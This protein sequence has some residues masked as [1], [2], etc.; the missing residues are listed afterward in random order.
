MAKAKVS[1]LQETQ[2]SDQQTEVKQDPLTLGQH[3]AAVL[4]H[5]DTPEH[6]FNQ[7]VDG[8]NELKTGEVSNSAQFIQAVIDR[9]RELH[10]E[11]QEGGA[12]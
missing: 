9:H 4:A 1:H 11:E 10:P 8:L 5:P 12:A 7:I 6:L 2:K 3:I